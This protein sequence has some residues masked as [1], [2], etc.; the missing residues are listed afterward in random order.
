MLW[1]LLD[2]VKER[3]W[4]GKRSKTF[5]YFL[6]VCLTTQISQ[7]RSPQPWEFRVIHE[8]SGSLCMFPFIT[9]LQLVVLTPSSAIFCHPSKCNKAYIVSASLQALCNQCEM[10]HTKSVWLRGSLGVQNKFLVRGK[11]LLHVI[12]T[13][14]KCTRYFMTDVPHISQISMSASCLG[15]VRMLNVSTPKEAS[16]ARANQVSC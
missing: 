13:I 9:S 14:R 7:S 16:G 6:S 4:G 2:T 3:C 8:C 1:P 10:R 15:S 5:C 12:S 11:T